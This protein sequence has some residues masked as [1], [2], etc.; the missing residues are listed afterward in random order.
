[1]ITLLADPDKKVR[2]RAAG[3]LAAVARSEHHHAVLMTALADPDP[4]RRWGAC[5]ALSLAGRS[6]SRTFGVAL[7]CLDHQDRDVA[8]AAAQIVVHACREDGSRTAVLR[9]LIADRAAGLRKMALYCLRDIGGSPMS[10]FC[11]ALE[12][13]STAVRLAALAG[14]FRLSREPDRPPAD[15]AVIT[16]VRDCLRCDTEPGVRRASA[17]VLGRIMNGDHESRRA[18]EAAAGDQRDTSLA[19]AARSALA[20]SR[21]G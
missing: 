4:E 7:D 6:S 3:A 16:R 18:L 5:C 17:A 9:R 14:L 20:A 10:L 2:R 13:T 12:D 21:G 8:W 19:R 11:E 15:A 1:L